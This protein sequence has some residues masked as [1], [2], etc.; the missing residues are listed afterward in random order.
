MD[1]EPNNVIYCQFRFTSVIF[2]V[3]FKLSTHTKFWSVLLFFSIVF[4][5]LGLYVGYMWFSDSYLVNYMYVTHTITMF[6]SIGSTYLI[7]LFSICFVLFID[8]FVLS[9]DFKRA[10]YSSKMRMIIE[11][12]K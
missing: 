5:S 3:T 6:F 10:G 2:L 4:L 9:I 11:S 8:G 7:V 12:E 1:S